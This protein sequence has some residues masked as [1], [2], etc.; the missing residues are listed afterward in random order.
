MGRISIAAICLFGLIGP[1]AYAQLHTGDLTT[2]LSGS[3]SAGYTADYGNLTASDHGVTAGGAATLTGAYYNPN[4]LSFN[5]QPFYNQSRTNSDFQSITDSSG[6]N[7]TTSIF[8]GSNFPGS[9]SYNKTFNG[10]GNFGIPGV[11]NFTSHGNSD[12]FSVGWGEHVAKLP[13]LS[14]SYQM[15]GSDYSIYGADTNSRNDF[16]SLVL[17]SSYSLLGFNLNGSYHY[18]A[19]KSELP[20]LYSGAELETSDSDTNSYSFGLGHRLPF[21][22]TFSAGATRS[23]LD[24]NSTLGSYNGTLDTAYS[25]LIFNPIERLSF[26]A[27]AQYLDNLIGEL[28]QSIAAAGGIAGEGLPLES[29]HALALSAFASYSVPAWHTSFNGTEQYQEQRFAGTALTDNS[30]TGTATYANILWGGMLNATAGA[31]RSTISPSD[32]THIGVIGSL[33]YSREVRR[34]SLSGLAN[35]AQDQQTLLASYLTN[36]FGYS[37]NASRRFGRKS[38]WSNVVSGTKSGLA[39]QS[40]T[41]SFSQAYSTSLF[42]RWITG[43]AAYS[44]SSGNAILTG[45]GLVATPIPLPILTP[46]AVVLYGGKAYSFGLGATPVRGLSLSVAYSEATSNTQNDASSSNNNTSQVTARILYIVR[47]TYFQAGYARLTQSFSASGFP[48]TMLGS[49]YFGLTRWFSFF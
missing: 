39:G 42:Y 37:G 40:G 11:A 23:D 43:T 7:A 46:A 16:H 10:E 17:N 14:F 45:T 6:V 18:S 19:V 28:Y 13:S 4:L 2:D 30:F 32:E 15:G 41:T 44:K 38:M 34:W 36:T 26:G 31:V 1:C 22:G 9:I 3:L 48:P 33:N 49:F 5:I 29:S 27:N 8:G 24:Y 47:K 21:H 25:G 12:V 20:Q 35:Y